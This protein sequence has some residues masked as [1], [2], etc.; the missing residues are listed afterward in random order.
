[1]TEF[2]RRLQ[3]VLGESR[4]NGD[5]ELPIGGWNPDSRRLSSN[6]EG[7]EAK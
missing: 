6:R 2:D 3:K 5:E 1:M 4:D 7:N